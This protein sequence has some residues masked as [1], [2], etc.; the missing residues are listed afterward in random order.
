MQMQAFLQRAL[1]IRREEFKPLLLLSLVYCA[2]FA[3]LELTGNVAEILFFRRMGVESLPQ[4][5]SIEPFIMVSLLLVFG[6]VVDRFSRYTLLSIMNGLFVVTLVIARLLINAH[7]SPVYPTLWLAQRVFFGLFPVVFWVLCSDI[8]DIRQ[9]KR[10][11]VIILAG[12]LAGAMIGNLL[13]G[14]LS[15]WLFPEDFLIVAMLIFASGVGVVEAVRRLR[16]PTSFVRPDMLSEKKFSLGL[17]RRLL[18]QPFLQAMFWLMLIIG[19]MEPVLRYELNALANQT[20][21][22]E[23]DLFTFYGFLKAGGALLVVIFQLLVA[24]RLVEKLGVPSMLSILPLGYLALLPLLSLLPNAFFGGFTVSLLVVFGVSF[25]SPA[26]SSALNLFPPEERGRISASADQLWYLGWLGGSVFLIW[27]GA[28][29]SLSGINVLAAAVAATWLFI[30]PSLRQRYA[31][32][33]LRNAD[34]PLDQHRAEIPPSTQDRHVI[35]QRFL[36]YLDANSNPPERALMALAGLKLR[37]PNVEARA[38]QIMHDLGE[39]AVPPLLS[40]LRS[41]SWAVRH[42]A[43]AMLAPRL[44]SRA[45]VNAAIAEQLRHAFTLE[46]LAAP[47]SVEPNIVWRKLQ[48]ETEHACVAAC[49]LLLE[50]LYPP[51]QMRAAARLVRATVPAARANGLEALD[52]LIRIEAKPHLMALIGDAPLAERRAH[53]ARW[54]NLSAPPTREAALEQLAQ[55][56]DAKVRFWAQVEA[57]R[58]NLALNGH[59]PVGG[60]SLPDPALTPLL[61][62]LVFPDQEKDVMELAHRIELL[63]RTRE[64]GALSEDELKIIALCL[65]EHTFAAQQ[66][67]FEEGQAS[68]SLYVLVEGKVELES[69]A[70]H[71]AVRELKAGDVFGQVPLLT[72]EPY[73]LTAL[74]L[75][76]ARLLALDRESLRELLDYYPD[77]ALGLLRALALQLKETAALAQRT[78]M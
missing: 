55:F 57:H 23:Q 6:S 38:D 45:A 4:L 27:A 56:P 2:V 63:R 21:T 9:S 36:Q 74:A 14:L 76:P 61:A 35:T 8:F 47:L 59:S 43:L 7:W 68:D 12:G 13:T 26:R 3:G 60:L 41:A 66:V 10:L 72:N 40:S 1:N 69:L 15:L 58:I 30:L 25:H 64:F 51:E 20:F 46:S 53:A 32:T 48:R 18:R 34:L 70:K 24:R 33:C 75:T 78:W 77:I 52:N 39:A 73:T 44:T 37:Q 49:L 16:L 65:R 19:F 11:F 50:L 29:W 22:A 67:V 17:P 71:Q 42:R 31:L 54:L 5:Y 62:A 28:R